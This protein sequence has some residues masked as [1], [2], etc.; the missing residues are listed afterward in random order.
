MRVRAEE[1]KR[2]PDLHS[3]EL[4]RLIPCCGAAVLAGFQ[5]GQLKGEAPVQQVVHH[6]LRP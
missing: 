5:M 4:Q 3:D 2:I 1:K 6:W